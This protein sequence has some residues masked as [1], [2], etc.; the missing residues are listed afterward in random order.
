MI[1]DAMQTIDSFCAAALS[2]IHLPMPTA[3]NFSA[4]PDGF[5]PNRDG[6]ALW[7]AMRMRY[8]NLEASQR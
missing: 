7:L 8:C 5:D 2:R 6:A 1:G 4:P 3:A